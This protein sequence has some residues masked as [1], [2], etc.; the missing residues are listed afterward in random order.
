MSPEIQAERISIANAVV[1]RLSMVF[2]NLTHIAFVFLVLLVLGKLWNYLWLAC[3][4]E[5]FVLS[6]VPRPRE[7]RREGE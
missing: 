4:R 5:S 3:N 1:M 2:I 7:S 6:E